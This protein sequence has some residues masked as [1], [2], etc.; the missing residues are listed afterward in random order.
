MRISTKGLYGT[1]AILDLSIHH[2]AG[3]VH[4]ADI[5]ARRGI[6]EQYLAQLLSTLRRA[7]YVKSL[8]GPAGG[9]MLARPPAEISVRDII[10]LLDGP[11]ATNAELAGADPASKAV[12]QKLVRDADQAAGAVLSSMTFDKVVERW[13]EAEDELD[14][15][16]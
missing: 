7:G 11:Q 3:H 16:I 15:A 2:A 12:I 10:E 14:F 4:K 13:R 6:P 5:A 9:H 1:L 8:R